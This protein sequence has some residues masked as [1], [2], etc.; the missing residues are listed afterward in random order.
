MESPSV[1][2]YTEPVNFDTITS[3]FERL[4]RGAYNPLEVLAELLL[5]GLSINWCAGVLHGTRGTRLLRGL[6]VMFIVATLVVRVLA[7]QFGWTRLELLY[8]AFV[9]GMAFIAL[10]AFQPEL[11]RALLRAGDV[12]FLRRRTPREILIAALV[13]SSGYLSKNRYGALIAIQR[14]VGLINWTENGTPMN[15]EVSGNLLKTIFFPNSALH[16]LGV[17]IRGNKVLAAGCQ[18]PVAESGEIDPSLGSRHRAAVG[19]S[20]ES[21]ALI[22]IVSEETGT[23]SLADGGKLTRFLSLDDLEQ[24][25]ETRLS[26]KSDPRRRTGHTLS[27]TWRY[28]RRLLIVLPLTLIVWFLVDQAS[29]IRDDGIEI[30]LT[31]THETDKY[32]QILR[33]DPPLFTLGVRG[34]T[35][36]IDELRTLTRERPLPVEWKLPIA[37]GRAGVYSLGENELHALLSDLPALQTRGVFVEDASPDPIEMR[38]DDVAQV[39]VPVRVRENIGDVRVRVDRIEPDQVEV[40]L[41][42]SLLDALPRDELYVEPAL[43]E[44]LGDA[45]RD[46][47]LTFAGVP[48]LSRHGDFSALQITPETVNLSLRVIAERERKRLGGIP[49]ELAVTPQFWKRYDIEIADANEWLL[50]VEVE[51]DR[52]V[53]AGLGADS[54]RALVSLTNEV[55]VATP[56]KPVS[57]NSGWPTAPSATS[58]FICGQTPSDIPCVP[59]WKTRSD[60]CAV[61]ASSLMMSNCRQWVT[62]FSQ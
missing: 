10:V 45:P 33:P 19:L 34:P 16:D 27:D 29:L 55:A 50:E 42:Q 23:L 54:V 18:F 9:V 26:G 52:S 8:R 15:A 43:Q 53:V 49:V 22:L 44:L 47:R 7:D 5:I 60:F 1:S 37:Y 25:L 36:R 41:P 28:L 2:F 6:L 46:Q 39:T 30:E 40:R 59:S 57:P 61:S 4:G 56:E 58:F 38:V 14:D 51:G 32:V 13:E 11:R 31:I 48:L 20:T 12:N 3:L 17:I 35:G 62:G 24:E 21:D